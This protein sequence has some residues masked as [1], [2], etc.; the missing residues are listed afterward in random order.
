MVGAAATPST[1]MKLKVDIWSLFDLFGPGCAA[2]GLPAERCGSLCAGCHADL[3]WLR[4]R[5]YCPDAIGGRSVGA[6]APPTAAPPTAIAPP[7]RGLAACAYAFPVDALV[8]Q[9]KFGGRLPVARPLGRLLAEAARERGG[10]LPQALVPVPL[11]PARERRRG[12]NQAEAIAQAVSHE[13]GIPLRTDALRRIRDTPA[14]SGLDLAARQRNLRD[15]FAVVAGAS[16]PAH[17]ALIDDVITSGSTMA[18]LTTLL[19]AHGVQHI[20]AWTVARTL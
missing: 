15:A 3:P 6:I 16:L 17:V 14:Q 4:G 10:R 8:Q 9:L 2:C 13:L 12:F 18:A 1:G 20:E 19:R 11:H 7:T 5:G